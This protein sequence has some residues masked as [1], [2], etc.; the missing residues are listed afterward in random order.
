M[1]GGVVSETPPKV[2]SPVAPEKLEAGNALAELGMLAGWVQEATG[3]MQQGGNQTSPSPHV[4][5]SEVEGAKAC[6]D[7]VEM[8][9]GKRRKRSS[10]EGPKLIEPKSANVLRR[11]SRTGY[12]SKYRGVTWNKGDSKWLAKIS[13]KGKTK[14]L[15]IFNEEED[16]ARAFDAEARR[17]RGAKASVNF[18]QTEMEIKRAGYSSK[19]RGV[20]WHK[21]HNKWRAEVRM[22]GKKVYLGHYDNEAEA[23]LAYDVYVAKVKRAVASR[24]KTV[25]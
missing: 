5:K 24:E 6:K 21:G 22:E 1:Q 9:K 10:S 17:V 14:Y 2:E 7:A 25:K 8:P 12:S 19:Y 20:S 15:G 18:P 3:T 16:A 23:A 4:V 13:V 11:F